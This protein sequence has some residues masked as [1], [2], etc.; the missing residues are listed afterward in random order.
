MICP[1]PSPAAT[2]ARAAGACLVGEDDLLA[3]I[4]AGE[5]KFDR[6]L[7]HLD[8]SAK[9]GKAGLGRILGPKG[10]MP[11]TKLG[12][13]VKDV[14]G[15]VRNMAGGSEYRERMGVIRMPVGQLGFTPEEV[16]KNIR[17]F[18]EGVKKDLAR[19]SDKI[20]KEIHEVVSFSIH[21]P[22]LYFSYLIVGPN[23]S[24]N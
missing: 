9:L 13:V 5:I 16:Q 4:K 2:A 8:S 1:D 10:L 3:S 14:A 21:P 19:L 7:C 22:L 23:P 17:A 6:L 18:M 15:T 12:T 24:P 11:S 20:N